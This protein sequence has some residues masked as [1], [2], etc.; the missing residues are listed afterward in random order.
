MVYGNNPY[1]KDNLNESIQYAVFSVP[2]KEI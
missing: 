1:T 2:P